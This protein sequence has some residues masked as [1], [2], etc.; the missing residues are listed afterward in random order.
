M[1]AGSRRRVLAAASLMIVWMIGVALAARTSTISAAPSDAVLPRVMN[2]PVARQAVPAA[3]PRKVPMSDEVFKNVQVLKGIP[4]DDFMQTMGYM[5]AA[6]GFDCDTCHD[7]AGTDQVKWEED[8]PNKR[9]A[10]RM[11]LMMQAINHDNFNGRQQVTCWTC[12]RGRDFPLVTPKLDSW[13]GE[14]VQEFDDVLAKADGVPSVDQILDK[15][16]QAIGGAQKLAR[17]TS[18]SA[19]GNSVGF[20]GFGG[21]GKVQILAQAPDKRATFV[22]FPDDPARG[23]NTRTYDGTSGWLTNPLAVVRKYE[24]GG[25]ELDGAKLDAQLSFPAQVKQTLSNLR[26]GPPSTI[27]D[28]DVWVIQGTGPRGMIASLYFDQSSGLLVRVIRYG[29]SPI[30]RL[31]TQVDYSDYRDVGGIKFPFHSTFSWLDGRDSF[32]FTD[33]Q[34]NVPIDTAKFGEPPGEK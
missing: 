15:Y 4:V 5:S 11:V 34:V 27:N 13:Y 33:V 7:R 29:R 1:K 24:L 14:P 19:K 23:N 6:L 17:V 8:T 3:T 32:E 26:S 12:H 28:K 31:P 20:G 18:F 22:T 16:Y 21:G 2:H 25:S 9:T 30:G 10:R